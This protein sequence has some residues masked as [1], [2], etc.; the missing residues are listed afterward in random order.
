MDRR[1]F[2]KK[3]LKLEEYYDGVERILE[4]LS[5]SKLEDAFLIA[6]GKELRTVD[7]ALFAM[8]GA[9]KKAAMGIREMSNQLSHE[10]TSLR[11]LLKSCAKQ[12]NAP[13]ASVDYLL[14]VMDRYGVFARKNAARKLTEAKALL[15]DLST[16]EAIPHVKALDGVS[17]RLNGITS[18]I[19]AL[20]KQQ[21]VVAEAKANPAVKVHLAELKEQAKLIVN[22]VGDYL[23]GMSHSDAEHYADSYNLFC[24]IIE[25]CNHPAE[26]DYQPQGNDFEDEDEFATEEEMEGTDDAGNGEAD[27]G[28]AAG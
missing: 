9:E 26:L 27:A 20:S 10:V 1:N 15:R 12:G 7:A 4:F 19:A 23:K 21:T 6:K 18:A 2:L 11:L 17:Q 28:N 8:V 16:E 14:S 13:Q 25:S 24:A 22:A 3:S 5:S